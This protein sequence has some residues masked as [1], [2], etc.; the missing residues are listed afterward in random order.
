MSALIE[1]GTDAIYQ[2]GLRLTREEAE[3]VFQAALS[4]I[5][6]SGTHKVAPV[7]LTPEMIEAAETC[8]EAIGAINQDMWSAMLSARPPLP[9][10]EKTYMSQWQPIETAPKDGTPI[11]VFSPYEV[12]TEPTNVIVAKFERHG[13]QEWWGY[14]ENL[15]ADVQGMIDPEPTHWMPLPSPPLPEREGKGQ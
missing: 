14:C 5:E 1:A 8:D 6:A 10:G 11:L 4:A 12:R 7:E 15:I 2:L 13:S 9:E 3:Q